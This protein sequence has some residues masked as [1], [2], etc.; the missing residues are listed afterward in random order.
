[1]HH[2]TCY[3]HSAGGCPVFRDAGSRVQLQYSRAE[4]IPH[5]SPTLPVDTPSL[6]GMTARWGA[7]SSRATCYMHHATCYAHSAGGCPRLRDDGSRVH[8]QVVQMQHAPNTMHCPLFMWMPCRSVGRRL[9]GGIIEPSNVIGSL[10]HASPT[11][12]V[13]A[14]PLDGMTWAASS[15]CLQLATCFAHP[16]R[17]T[18]C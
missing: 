1:M 5:A 18:P 11:L 2:A 9:A 6:G 13:D 3:A 4:E 10:L 16:L 8:R 12:L 17:R 14:L 7:P 15:S